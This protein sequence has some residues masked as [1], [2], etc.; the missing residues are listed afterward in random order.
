[1]CNVERFKMSNGYEIKFIYRLKTF[2]VIDAA[3]ETV[4]DEREIK[5]A[6]NGGRTQEELKLTL[7]VGYGI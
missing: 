4:K 3:A 7:I 5:K 6:T 1:M 2:F